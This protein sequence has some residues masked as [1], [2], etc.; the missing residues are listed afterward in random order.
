MTGMLQALPKTPLHAR[1]AKEGRLLHE[2]NGDQFAFS[3]I[4]PAG[5]SR[6]RLYEGYRWLLSQLYDFDNYRKRTLD[7]LLHR[8]NQIHRGA[9][10]RKGDL[11]RLWRV[12]SA[13]IFRG[14]P[15]RAWFTVRLLGATLLRRPSAFKDAVSFAVIHQAFHS[16]MERLATELDV[17]IRSLEEPEPRATLGCEPL[18]YSRN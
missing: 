10:I 4:L 8:G 11:R 15:R 18:S 5:M 9:N 13:T 1:V 12:L 7:F 2:T 17:A 3:N 14:G 16:Y 6:R